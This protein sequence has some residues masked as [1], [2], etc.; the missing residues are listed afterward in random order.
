[1]TQEQKIRKAEQSMESVK[2]S[3][4]NL[5]NPNGSHDKNEHIKVLE[6]AVARLVWL[7]KQPEGTEV[8][9]EPEESKMKLVGHLTSCYGER[10]FY[11]CEVGH[12]V[13]EKNGRY[14]LIYDSVDGKIIGKETTFNPEELSKIMSP[15][16]ANN[17][18][19]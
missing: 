7:I 11:R 1:M 12:E 13:Y 16:T 9:Q 18:N 14:V 19:N 10:G 4:K 3:L 2:R 15:I 5:A 6:L 8:P 17:G